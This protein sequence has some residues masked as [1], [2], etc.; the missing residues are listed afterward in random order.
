MFWM[1]AARAF[2]A[3]VLRLGVLRDREIDAAGVAHRELERPGLDCAA[4]MAA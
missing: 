4:M 2:T 3:H 1:I